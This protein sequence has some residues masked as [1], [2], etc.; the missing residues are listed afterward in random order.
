MTRGDTRTGLGSY[1][2][3]KDK[4][5]EDVA[6]RLNG[7][8]RVAFI[9]RSV[10]LK[11][12]DDKGGARPRSLSFSAK[13]IRELGISSPL[14]VPGPSVKGDAP[15]PDRGIGLGDK[16]VDFGGR[17]GSPASADSSI[18]PI[19]TPS[20]G[21][22][23]S[24]VDEVRIVSRPL[25]PAFTSV[26]STYGLGVTANRSRVSP[27]ERL[28]EAMDLH[29]EKRSFCSILS[30]EETSQGPKL[31]D[32]VPSPSARDRGPRRS[33]LLEQNTFFIPPQH[34][35]PSLRTSKSMGSSTM[36][37]AFTS[38]TLRADARGSTISPRTRS[39]VK[40]SPEI[41]SPPCASPT[42]GFP[43]PSSPSMRFRR[44]ITGFSLC[45]PPNAIDPLPYMLPCTMTGDRECQSPK[46][47][48]TRSNKSSP[49]MSSSSSF[50][51]IFGKDGFVAR[52]LTQAFDARE[53]SSDPTQGSDIKRKIS[54]PLAASRTGVTNAAHIE[55]LALH[56]STLTPV[57]SLSFPK[58]C[59]KLAEPC[60]INL[61][62]L[63][64]CG[65]YSRFT[66]SHERSSPAIICDRSESQ[67]L[68][69]IGQA[70]LSIGNS[71][72]SGLNLRSVNV[73]RFIVPN[74]VP[75]VRKGTERT[76]GAQERIADSA[77]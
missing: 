76:D 43:P 10:S 15:S 12:S 72:E 74:G 70:M 41:R 6:Q 33:L 60:T 46:A 66:E 14:Q 49:F 37:R 2:S 59:D 23:S 55:N 20:S 51:V 42:T 47:R 28:E 31:S 17:Y 62:S 73:N 35:R 1:S 40:Y 45:S 30:A 5:R 65:S 57:V 61:P 3:G 64:H 19:M 29:D 75:P 13:S 58:R 52:S 8:G 21:C 16:S 9:R 38:A 53:K 25:H 39:D 68:E 54:D 11:R 34:P 67:H 50:Q 24:P 22:V 77:L 48:G 63:D 69:D 44:P 18:F 27:R 56:K 71:I 4:A 36:R 7:E 26:G 32:A